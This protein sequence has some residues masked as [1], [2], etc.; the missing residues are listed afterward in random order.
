MIVR[1]SV[2]ILGKVHALH[3]LVASGGVRPAVSKQSWESRVL[4]RILERCHGDLVLFGGEAARFVGRQHRRF[5][6]P[7]KNVS[8]T[9]L[10]HADLPTWTFFEERID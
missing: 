6:G 2:Y 8:R 10:G 9:V 7:T 1:V 4:E 5:S 3:A